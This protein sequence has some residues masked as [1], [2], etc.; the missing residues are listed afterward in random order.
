LP[1]APGH[2]AQQELLAAWINLND[3]P[4][5]RHARS[6]QKLLQGHAPGLGKELVRRA[7]KDVARMVTNDDYKS[8]VTEARTALMSCSPFDLPQDRFAIW[9]SFTLR[10]VPHYRS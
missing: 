7:V 10:F 1:S 6:L 8:F 2:A 5:G 9:H 4:F 3:Q